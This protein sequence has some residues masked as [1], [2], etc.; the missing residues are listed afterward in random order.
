M[1]PYFYN[2]G[3]KKLAKEITGEEN[4]YLGIRPYGFHA[5]NMLSHVV[6]PILLGQE[7]AQRGIEPK[8]NIYIFINDWEQGGL[9][10]PDLKKYPFNIY[11]KDFTFQYMRDPKNPNINIV[12]YWEPIIVENVKNIQTYFPK[13]NIKSVRNSAMKDHPIMKKYLLYTIG[14]PHVVANILKKTRK[15]VLDKPI[16]YALAVCPKCNKVRGETILKEEKII[17]RCFNCNNKT[18]GDY[19]DFDYWFYHKPLA[20]P[21]LE[22]YNINICITGVDHYDEGDFIIRKELIKAYGSKA[23][24]PKTLYTQLILAR[25]GNVMEKSKGN[26]DIVD[27]DYLFNLFKRFPTSK[28]IQIDY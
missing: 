5:G 3:I 18:E 21:R 8:F 16:S 12:D 27:L 14:N 7:L 9:A 11:P 15:T 2:N 28:R 13:I 6:Y 19:F 26:T 1:K 20:L 4:I 23:K 22:I 24:Y 25:D 10:G 17:H